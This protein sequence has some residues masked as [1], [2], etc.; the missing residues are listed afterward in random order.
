MIINQNRHRTE[1]MVVSAVL[2]HVSGGPDRTVVGYWFHLFEV[3]AHID[4]TTYQHRDPA[5][6]Q[7]AKIGEHDAIALIL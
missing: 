2:A 5:S 7:H 1:T 3:P 6:V 4:K